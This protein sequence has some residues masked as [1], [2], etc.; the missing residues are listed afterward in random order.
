MAAVGCFVLG[1]A[2]AVGLMAV[3]LMAVGLMTAGLMAADLMAADLMAA[4]LMAAGLMAAGLMAAGHSAVGCWCHW[5]T[6]PWVGFPHCPA[7]GQRQAAG[8]SGLRL[9]SCTSWILRG[10]RSP[11]PILQQ[12]RCTPLNTT[13]HDTVQYSAVQCSMNIETQY[14]SMH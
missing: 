1:F 14:K 9:P 8:H 3:G 13:Q 6:A 2:A 10:P 4:G 7:P 12:F 5:L 11:P